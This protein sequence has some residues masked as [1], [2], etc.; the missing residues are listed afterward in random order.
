MSQC[1]CL[2]VFLDTHDLQ[3]LF[4]RYNKLPQLPSSLCE[5]T[6]LEEISLESNSLQSLPVSSERER[7]REGERERERVREREREREKE[8][9]R[10]REGEGERERE[11]EREREKH[12]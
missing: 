8:R 12:S 3:N 5:C 4:F 11:R 10:E 6:Q 1:V 9:G 7:E 2:Y